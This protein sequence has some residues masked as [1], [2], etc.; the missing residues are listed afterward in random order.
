MEEFHLFHVGGALQQ[1]LP[2][3]YG[4]AKCTIGQITYDLLFAER[5]AFTVEELFQKLQREAPNG[6]NVQLV[7]YVE[8]EKIDTHTWFDFSYP[9]NNS[10]LNFFSPE[11]LMLASA[12]CFCFGCVS[13][14]TVKHEA[15]VSFSLLFPYV[16]LSVM[17]EGCNLAGA[18]ELLLSDWHI[19]NI[20]VTD[21]EP[22]RIV[23][24]DWAG[25]NISPGTT[26]KERMKAAKICFLRYLDQTKDLSSFLHVC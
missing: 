1:I 13:D 21:R 9:K 22:V 18:H 7:S 8:K 16:I 3:C 6:Y 25:H 19:A 10:S 11:I 24:I 17:K 23:L 4:V 15:W 14:A 26:G 2:R 20:A 5:I 12:C